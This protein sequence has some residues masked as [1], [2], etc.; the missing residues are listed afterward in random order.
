M[1]GL[2]LTSG[3]ED[4]GCFCSFLEM[5]FLPSLIPD[6]VSDVTDELGFLGLSVKHSGQAN[7]AVD[8]QLILISCNI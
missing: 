3:M 4:D 8:E 5:N 1:L 6:K 7:I 2:L